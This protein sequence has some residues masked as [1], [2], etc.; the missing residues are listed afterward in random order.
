V[1]HRRRAENIVRS[2]LAEHLHKSDTFE[3]LVD[4]TAEG[5]RQVEREARRH[6]LRDAANEVM[7]LKPKDPL[8]RDGLDFETVRAAAF[9][10][11]RALERPTPQPRRHRG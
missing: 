3:V 4:R 10:K 11:V 7:G 5:L 2:V 6:A 8:L 1:N 9:R